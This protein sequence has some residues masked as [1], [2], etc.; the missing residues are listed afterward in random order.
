MT[1]P[2]RQ[3]MAR[4]MSSVVHSYL[5]GH[6]TLKHPPF[7][8]WI[9]P[10]SHC[11]I[12]CE[13][14]PTPHF[15]RDMRGFMSFDLFKHIID[16]VSPF[17]N[18]VY[19]FHRGESLLNPHIADMVAYA[20]SNGISTK[21][22]TNVTML[23]EERARALLEA[24]IDL[25]SFSIDGYTKEVYESIRH[26]AKWDKVT[27][28][29]RR[30]L[31]LKAEGG[32]KTL[33]Q[34]EVLEFRHKFPSE[35]D[36]RRAQAEFWAYFE[37]FTWDKRTMRGL[38]NVGGNIDID[39]SDG[40]TMEKGTYHHCSYPWY[41]VAILWSGKVQPCPRDFMGK[42]PIGDITTDHILDIWNGERM[43]Q[44]RDGA[45]RHDFSCQ[46]VCNGCDQPYKYKKFLMGVPVDYIPAYFRD[47]PLR[48]GLRRLLQGVPIAGKHLFS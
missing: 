20:K 16:Q 6:R 19:L 23:N 7:R 12:A 22:N 13:M 37:P 9:E 26:K 47:S 43:R 3:S 38:H 41:A 8:M 34:M 27:T 2:P 25:L 32:Y 21:L 48:Y 31:E 1:A 42:M 17:M 15:S 28:N 29:A 44:I 30:F 33:V 40:Y 39:E 45:V 24:G 36:F 11:N 10:T 46:E 35:E 14:C 5:S 4:L 18:E